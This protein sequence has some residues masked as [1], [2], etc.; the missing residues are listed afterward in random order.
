[1]NK[2]YFTGKDQVTLGLTNGIATLSFTP[3]TT[4]D[5]VAINPLIAKAQE[6]QQLG[7]YHIIVDMQHVDELHLLGTHAL[8]EIRDCCEEHNG[9]LLVC[10]AARAFFFQLITAQLTP[11]NSWREA[12]NA[13]RNLQASTKPPTA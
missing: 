9:A 4:L 3:E 8:A 13:L 1:M 2:L 7:Y 12:R 6:A 10:N 5:E 11:S